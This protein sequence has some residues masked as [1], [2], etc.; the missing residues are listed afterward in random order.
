MVK[1]L[2]EDRKRFFYDRQYMRDLELKLNQ[3][4]YIENNRINLLSPEYYKGNR[5]PDRALAGSTQN[6]Q[7]A[8][9]YGV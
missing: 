5:V 6:R 8:G 4:I 9:T 3:R 7:A 1:V 2:H